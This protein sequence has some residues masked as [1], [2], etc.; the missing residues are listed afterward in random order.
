MEV[1][2]GALVAEQV[3]S[4]AV[5]GAVVGAA[6]AARRTLPLKAT[7]TRIATSQ[8]QPSR[9][10]L[11]RISCT[12][13]IVNGHAYIFG[14]S[15]EE[16]NQSPIAG[17]EM[18]IIRISGKY[19]VEFDYKCVPAL[20]S[21]DGRP[22]PAPRKAHSAAVYKDDILIFG[23]PNEGG[24]VWSFSTDT[25]R[26]TAREPS[27][28]RSCQVSMNQGA[29]VYK[30]LFIV[31]GSA[32][33]AV[34]HL[35]ET[36]A[37]DVT[38]NTWLHVASL[39]TESGQTLTKPALVGRTLFAISMARDPDQDDH[40]IWLHYLYLQEAGKLMEWESIRLP[41]DP[42]EGPLIHHGSPLVPV[43]TGLGRHY[44]LFQAGRAANFAR[45]SGDND[46]EQ[47]SASSDETSLWA[48][49]IP[50]DEKSLAKLKDWVRDKFGGKSGT[51]QCAEVRLKK[52]WGKSEETMSHPGPR[53]HSA[54][55]KVDDRTVLM[56][57]GTYPGFR[58]GQGDGWMI[59]LD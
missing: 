1:A 22:V 37:F 52:S 17:N 43:S 6:L 48:M 16:S 11:H 53:A 46:A 44:L 58:E 24:R 21:I 8:D 10:S 49:Q 35:Q 23:G 42:L 9:E 36:W 32:F 30:D 2:A 7:F 59:N 14:G 15:S 31:H 18:H 50:S 25:L 5:E 28:G 13:N 34:S 19:D 47:A 39:R 41:V 29:I 51:R 4:T 55:A 57:C 26:W 45:T 38:T 3:V 20:P 40:A 33:Q 12:V 56:W 54:M 27:D